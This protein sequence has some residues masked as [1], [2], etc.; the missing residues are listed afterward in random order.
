MD[1]RELILFAVAV[2]GCIF[3]VYQYIKKNSKEDSKDVKEN[4]MQSALIMN[5]L[6]HISANVDVIKTDVKVLNSERNKDREDILILGE[7]HEGLS[8]KLSTA[9]EKIDQLREL[10]VTRKEFDELKKDVDELKK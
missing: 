4:A 6:K 2:F 5:E 1:Y 3:G 8:G 7:R 9:F 10:A